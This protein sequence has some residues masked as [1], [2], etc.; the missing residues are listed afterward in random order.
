MAVLERFGANAVSMGFGML[1]KT[2]SALPAWLGFT[3]ATWAAVLSLTKDF[4]AG[5]YAGNS[6]GGAALA[7]VV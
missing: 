7:V 3:A 1:V 6:S 5:T 4:G 2:A